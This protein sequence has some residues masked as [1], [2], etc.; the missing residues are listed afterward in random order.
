MKEY[1]SELVDWL[2]T[3]YSARPK[4]R[5]RCTLQD[6]LLH[7][8]AAVPCALVVNE[9]V[10]NSLKHAFPR[11]RRGI[12]D[13]SLCTGERRKVILT[14]AD[15]G[16][17]LPQTVNLSAPTSLGMDLVSR[18]VDQLQGK[19]KVSRKGGSSFTIEFTQKQ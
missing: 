5:L 10:T 2:A 7:S 8:D 15:D 14:V 1:L 17:G 11:G 16:I 12:V 13:I 9:L 4:I 19:F 18:W 3:L 6:I